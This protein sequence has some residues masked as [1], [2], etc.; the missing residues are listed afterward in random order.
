MIT[1]ALA[2][3]SGWG[4]PRDIKSGLRWLKHAERLG[5]SVARAL[6]VDATELM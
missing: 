4:A 5:S 2:V 3:L 1:L 6:L